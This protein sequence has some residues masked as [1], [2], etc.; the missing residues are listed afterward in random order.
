MVMK[1]A[2]L[3]CGFKSASVKRNLLKQVVNGVGNRLQSVLFISGGIDP[4]RERQDT[5]LAAEW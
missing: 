2:G 3:H 4:A 1:M 5:G